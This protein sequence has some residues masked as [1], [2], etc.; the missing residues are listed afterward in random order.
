[1]T[2]APRHSSN[3]ELD[4]LHALCER[5]NGFGAALSVEY[6]DGWLT[7]LACI[8]RQ[9]PRDE[10]LPLL[11]DDTF[12]R[13]YADPEDAAPALA[14]LDARR[15]VLASQLHADV[16]YE[17]PDRLR[18]SPLITVWDDATREAQVAAGDIDADEAAQVL[19][20]GA[21]WAEGF[22]DGAAALP[23]DWPEPDPDS[24][25]GAFFASCLDHVFA[26]LLPADD[27]ERYLADEYPGQTLSRD[28]LVDEA[29]FAVQDLRLMA[30]EQAPRPETRRVAPQPGRN[31]P[32]PCGSGKKFKKCHGA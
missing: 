8:V 29:C 18:L 27:L 10:W 16:L 24:E 11:S 23:G 9:V 20:T 15:R 22:R 14:A 30:I 26:L 28:D 25:D 21:V 12:D 3:A 5:L 7:A 31:D 6:V 19:R 1:M 17:A 2:P 4:A 32:C 13:A